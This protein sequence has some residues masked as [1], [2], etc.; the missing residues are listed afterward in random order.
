[1]KIIEEGKPWWVGKQVRCERCKCLVEMERSDKLSVIG[2]GFSGETRY[3]ITCPTCDMIVIVLGDPHIDRRLGAL[4]ERDRQ[5]F[6]T[7]K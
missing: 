5:L 1:M 6:E 2:D 3:A 7:I 4:L